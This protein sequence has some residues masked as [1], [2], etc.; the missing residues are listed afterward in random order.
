MSVKLS[1]QMKQALS[2]AGFFLPGPAVKNLEKWIAKVKDLE[3]CNQQLE[4]RL[5][6]WK[7]ACTCGA[8]K[9][10]TEGEGAQTV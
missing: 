7:K 9:D 10:E 6:K 3:D 1:A 5:E 8:C 2:K 4:A